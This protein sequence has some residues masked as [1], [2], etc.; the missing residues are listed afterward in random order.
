MRATLPPKLA[1][2]F[3]TS[4]LPWQLDKMPNLSELAA[5]I[6]TKDALG[7]TRKL[8]QAHVVQAAAAVRTALKC[9]YPEFNL[10]YL[11]AVEDDFRGLLLGHL[12]AGTAADAA[13]TRAAALWQDNM[14]KLQRIAERY[15]QGEA[16]GGKRADLFSQAEL[17]TALEGAHEAN[18]AAVAMVA[19]L[20]RSSAPSQFDHEAAGGSQKKKLASLVG[21]WRA[22]FGDACIFHHA[23]G[24]CSQGT[25]CPKE[26][27][28]PVDS[29][30]V[31]EWV[32][33]NNADISNACASRAVRAAGG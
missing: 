5:E 11:L 14:R 1:R 20:H 23:R 9:A 18:S 28:K 2:E 17:Y 12:E 22:A 13:R 6:K 29:A 32:K 10:D 15:R 31:L 8:Q 27:D 33:A 4:L 25:T 7:E 26:H 30:K 3:I 24:R 16:S 21:S 19:S